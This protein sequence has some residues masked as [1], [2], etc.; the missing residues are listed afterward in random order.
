MPDRQMPKFEKSSPELVGR[1][2]AVLDRQAAPDI[3][4][5]QMFGYPCAWIGGN[6]VSG[7]FA[8]EWWVRVSEPDRE[9]LLTLPGAHQFEVMPGKAMGRYVVMPRE[10]VADDAH[11]DSWLAKA[12]EFTRTLPPKI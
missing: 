5:K 12:I 1:Y 3:T 11:L 9:A 2:Q 6:M 4:R 10:V 7:L 8:Q